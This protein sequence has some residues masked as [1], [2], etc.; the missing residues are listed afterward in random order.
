[1]FYAMFPFCVAGL[2]LSPSISSLKA[3]PG[4]LSEKFRRVDWI[5]GSLFILSGTVF[6]IAV[7]WGGVQYSWS[8]PGTI[9]PLCLGVVGLTWTFIYEARWCRRPF[10]RRSLFLNISSIV[11]YIC[12]TIQGLIVCR[13]LAVSAHDPMG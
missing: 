10:L 5:G 11:T 3:P 2:L 7:S 4:T 9:V 13:D 12:G 1:V 6:L 8:S